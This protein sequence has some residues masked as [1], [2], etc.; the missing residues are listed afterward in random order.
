MY[1]EKYEKLFDS[2]FTY[3]K[4]YCKDKPDTHK[5]NVKSLFEYNNSL[6]NDFLNSKKE[7]LNKKISDK[8]TEIRT[9][10]TDLN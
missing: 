5:E 9:I 8:Q 2:L 4:E 10:Y 1:I 6:F 3:L 7:L